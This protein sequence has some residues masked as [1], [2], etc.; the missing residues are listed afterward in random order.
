ML[1]SFYPEY[2]DNNRVQI[3]YLRYFSSIV[4]GVVGPKEVCVELLNRIY[5]WCYD[6]NFNIS[7]NI[8][9]YFRSIEFLG[10]N[11]ENSI[12]QG[13]YIRASMLYDY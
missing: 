6:I 9:L 1:V 8:L 2:E 13:I 10:Y 12:S 4:V 7:S 11:V 3:F 5:G